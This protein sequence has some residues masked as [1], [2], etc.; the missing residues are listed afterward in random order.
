MKRTA[1]ILLSGI[2][3][4]NWVGYRLFTSY[5]ESKADLQLQAQLDDNNYEESELISIKAPAS[6]LPYYTNSKQFERVDGQV[7]IGGIQYKYVKRRLY[8]DSLE[9]MCIPNRAAMKL[10]TAKDEFFKLVNDL[11]HN[12]QS[13]K[14]GSH[15]GSSKNFSVD[16]YTV[17]DLLNINDLSFTTTKRSSGYS[18]LIRSVYIPT[19]E[20]PPEFC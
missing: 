12:G 14:T 9:L 7:E 13:K 4:F 20:Q 2:L 17:N 15:P 19:V 6:S 18:F 5:L 1:A 3:F 11:Q 16:N 10:Q 8:N